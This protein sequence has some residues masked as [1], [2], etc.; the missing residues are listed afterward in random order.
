[1]CES[2]QLVSVEVVY[3][4]FAK[5]FDSRRFNRWL[6]SCLSRRSQLL[7]SGCSF[8]GSLLLL[9]FICDVKLLSIFCSGEV[10]DCLLR[11]INVS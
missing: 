3:A 5:A 9:V 8:L 2:N 4:D 7:L 1:M 11:K 6:V 10:V